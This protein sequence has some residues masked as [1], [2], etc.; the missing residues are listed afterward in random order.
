M[1]STAP[2]A[3]TIYGSYITHSSPYAS[4]PRSESQR[5]YGSVD[6]G[7]CSR[8]DWSSTTSVA[9][10]FGAEPY[11]STS[12]YVYEAP[13][14]CPTDGSYQRY[15]ETDQPL[16]QP[17]SVR[18]STSYSYITEPNHFLT[19][20]SLEDQ[21]PNPEP[22]IYSSSTWAPTPAPPPPHFAPPYHHAEQVSLSEPS[23]HH[24]QPHPSAEPSTG[25]RAPHSLKGNMDRRRSSSGSSIY[26]ARGSLSRRSSALELAS[27][28]GSERSFC[29]FGSD[30]G[31]E[32]RQDV[33]TPFMS[34]LHLLLNNPEYNEVIRWNGAGDQFIFARD[35]QE[36]SE[37]LS[38]VFRHG[39]SHSF[40]RQLNIYDFK[41]LSSLELHTAVE[42]NPH[43]CSPL[44]SADFAGFAHPLFFRDRP[45]RLCDLTKIKP[46]M[47]KKPSTRDP[48][49]MAKARSSPYSAPVSVRTRVLRSDGGRIGG[50]MKGRMI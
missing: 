45:G 10:R 40:V 29:S 23:S 11:A 48:S 35:T 31:D 6:A 21:L 12:A 26:E 27:T 41:R 16:N 43:P 14:H 49:V 22:L 3:R 18:P 34:K 44:S 5:V 7:P 28:F 33:V 24:V 17:Q 50:S 42:S 32:P 39:N 38:K 9:P 8:A 4:Y 13:L 47:G 19:T 2:P 15:G 20:P 25:L 37:A 30:E 46:K 36:L 1:S